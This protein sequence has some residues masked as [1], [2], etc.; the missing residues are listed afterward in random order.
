MPID[1][2]NGSIAVSGA[3]ATVNIGLTA[4][5]LST[6]VLDGIRNGGFERGDLSSWSLAGA[7]V[8]RQQL[9]PTSTGVV[10]RPTEGQWMVGISTGAGAVGSIGS[11]IRQ[12]FLVPSGVRTLRLDFNF[13]SEEFPEFVG[14]IFDDSFRA[15]AET[16]TEAF[17]ELARRATERGVH[18]AD[19][20]ALP[21]RAYVQ[22]LA[23]T[24]KRA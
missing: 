21:V 7:A 6:P 23:A 8:V 13:V 9:G 19:P 4:P 15:I 20:F 14:T 18:V 24:S 5:A 10:I 17:T 16:S 11:S 12:R 22:L 2:A 3:T 1:T